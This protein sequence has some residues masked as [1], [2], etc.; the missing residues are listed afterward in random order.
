MSVVIRG[1]VTAYDNIANGSATGKERVITGTSLKTSG[2]LDN[3]AVGSSGCLMGADNILSGSSEHTT[4]AAEN[5]FV[6]QT[7]WSSTW[8]D[9]LTSV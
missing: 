6:G 7:S 4:G 8:N 2:A 9:R 3:V 5:L 1:R